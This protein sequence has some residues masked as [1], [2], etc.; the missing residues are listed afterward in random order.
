MKNANKPI[1]FITLAVIIAA[2]GLA[3][4]ASMQVESLDAEVV[5]PERIGQGQS[6]NPRDVTVYGTY[7][8]GSRKR[9]NLNSS[10]ISYNDSAA[11]SQRVTIK[12][13][14]KEVYFQIQVIPLTSIRITSQP[15]KVNY[16][17][18]QGLELAGLTAVG[19]WQGL[20][21]ADIPITMNDVSGHKMDTVGRQTVTV[22]KY[23][24]TAT[25]N[26]TVTE[27][28]H[29]LIGT[30]LGQSGRY[31]FRG[32]NTGEAV[33]SRG[34]YRITWDDDKIVMTVVLVPL[35]F[36]YAISG[37]TLT[38]TSTTESKSTITVTRQQ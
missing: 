4:C 28:Y 13:S 18:W 15:T 30:W 22:N 26:I 29:P 36:T 10:Q 25:F 8:D 11:G 3:G 24:R 9:V 37:N 2:I 14:G 12:V 20:P 5:G 32:D 38:M 23:G 31:V 35:T 34:T 17:Q 19:T 7:K 21:E 6:I 33:E 1:G 27:K 16:E